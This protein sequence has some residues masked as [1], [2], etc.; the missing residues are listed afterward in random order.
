M[1]GDIVNFNIDR[2]RPICNQIC[3]RICV[4]IA[5][6]KITAKEKLS[7]VREFAVNIGVNPNTIQKSYDMLEKNGIIYSIHGSGWYVSENVTL[8]KKVVE[9]IVKNKIDSFLSE[10]NEL[11]FDNETTLKLLDKRLGDSNE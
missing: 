7:S 10:M 6:N 5:N 9:E 11:G 1:R 8:A 2:S 3:E 4:L